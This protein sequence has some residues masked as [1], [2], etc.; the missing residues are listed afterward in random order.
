M[1]KTK[2]GYIDNGIL[3][4]PSEFSI[5]DTVKLTYHGPLVKKGASEI[6]AHVGFGS[7]EWKNV[8]SVKMSKTRKGFET[9]IPV[10]STS[11]LNIVFKDASETW[12]N[13]DGQNYSVSA[14]PK[15]SYSNVCIKPNEFT[16]GDKVKLVYKGLLFKN[17]SSEVYAHIGYGS[18]WDD[19]SDIKM[20]KTKSGFEA[21]I[22]ITCAESLNVAFK[23]DT[24]NWD[25]NSNKNYILY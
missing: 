15:Y 12:D 14:T 21:E 18:N 5:G 4:T 10:V 13:N 17:K 3:V 22:I 23:D 16:I 11:N 19:L 8:N 20:N 6:Y 7:D 1:P 2:F 25:N 9:K 24:D